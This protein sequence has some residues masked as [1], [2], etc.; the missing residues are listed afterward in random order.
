MAQ[1]AT[2]EKPVNETTDGSVDGKTLSLNYRFYT[3]L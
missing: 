2:L 3:N 1:V